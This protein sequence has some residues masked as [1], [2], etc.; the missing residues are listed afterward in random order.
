MARINIGC[1]ALVGINKTGSLKPD[2]DGYY[3]V[4]LGALEFKN[5][6]GEIYTL[7]SAKRMFEE[8]SAFMRRLRA[9]YCKGE[10]GH[11]KKVYVDDNNVVHRLTDDEFLIRIM[12]IEETRVCMDIIE[13]WIDC[14][15]IRYRNQPVVAIMGRIKPSGPFGP[16]LEK[17][18]QSPK[19]NVAFSVRAIS[20]N[21]FK[22][23]LTHK[24]FVEIRGWDQVTEPG[25]APANIFC[26][27]G[28]ESYSE[29]NENYPLTEEMISRAATAVKRGTAMG[30]SLES[31]EAILGL[32]KRLCGKSLTVK[33]TRSPSSAW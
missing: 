9:G 30:I 29:L 12:T 10:L 8:S 3:T 26:A 13:V 14:D 32:Q 15:S 33:S 18:L 22:G 25:L 20:D 6:V 27:P 7:S 24:D 28:L 1:S 23:G 11:P 4:V 19:E 5:S 17:Q 21:Y 31:G 16:A 2:A